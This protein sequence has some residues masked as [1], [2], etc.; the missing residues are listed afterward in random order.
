MEHRATRIG[1]RSVGKK[2]A[3]RHDRSGLADHATGLRAGM[4]ALATRALRGRSDRSLLLELD[5][6]LLRDIGLER[7]QLRAAEYGGLHIEQLRAAAAGRLDED[8]SSSAAED[9]R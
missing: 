7:S 1:L 2:A 5:D 9:S 6:R 4:V 3:A 8:E